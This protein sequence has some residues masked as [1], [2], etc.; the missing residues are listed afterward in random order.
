M[1]IFVSRD[2]R[3]VIA[4]VNVVFVV[5]L[6]ILHSS[7]FVSAGFLFSLIQKLLLLFFLMAKNKYTKSFLLF[8]FNKIMN[9]IEMMFCSVLFCLFCFVLRFLIL[10]FSCC[11]SFGFRQ[12]SL[13]VCFSWHLNQICKQKRKN[14]EHYFLEIKKIEKN[15]WS[16]GLYYI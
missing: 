12:N 10:Y 9:S 2:F 5:V 15:D 4:F 6:L 13:S 14:L 7:L 11:F 8:S 16:S 3:M 1:N